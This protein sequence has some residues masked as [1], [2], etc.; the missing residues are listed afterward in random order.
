M[1]RISGRALSHAHGVIPYALFQGR[2]QLE[3]EERE[4]RERKRKERKRAR[5]EA[6]RE[7]G[8]QAAT[9]EDPLGEASSVEDTEGED[10]SGNE[11]GDREATVRK[12]TTVPVESTHQRW[13]PHPSGAQATPLPPPRDLRTQVVS[14]SGD[15]FFRVHDSVWS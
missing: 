14:S 1:S 5:T 2:R 8:E 4:E 15:G 12:R 7:A 13:R 10:R 3:R 11:A 9:V 6:G